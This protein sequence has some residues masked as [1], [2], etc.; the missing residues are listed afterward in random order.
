MMRN[1]QHSPKVA[2]RFREMGKHL[3]EAYDVLKRRFLAGGRVDGI[4]AEDF[5]ILD[6]DVAVLKRKAAE[7]EKDSK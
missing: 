6:G 2:E 7:A 3:F 1:R 5:E 4:D